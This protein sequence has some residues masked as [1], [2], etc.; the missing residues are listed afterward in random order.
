MAGFLD[1]GLRSVTRA[2]NQ[3]LSAESGLMSHPKLGELDEGSA[4]PRIA[5]FRDPLIVIDL[6]AL[7][8]GG[9]EARISGKLSARLSNLTYGN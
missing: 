5:S 4:Q 6:A 9:S 2:M 8:M 3:R 7:P 1:L